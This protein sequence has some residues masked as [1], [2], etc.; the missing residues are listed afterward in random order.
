M[1]NP[2][3]DSCLTWAVFMSVVKAKMMQVRKVL[4]GAKAT[5]IKIDNDACVETKAMMRMTVQLGFPKAKHLA[6]S[7]LRP[8]Y[9]HGFP[10]HEIE[11]EFNANEIQAIEQTEAKLF[12]IEGK[13]TADDEIDL[14]PPEGMRQLSYSWIDYGTTVTIVTPSLKGLKDVEMLRGLEADGI[15]VHSGHKQLR[16]VLRPPTGA[17]VGCMFQLH[18]HIVPSESTFR[19][20]PGNRLA[21]TLCKAA[22]GTWPRLRSEYEIVD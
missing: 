7:H 2:S 6:V 19:L 21:I 13:D 12:W 4:P 15:E 1:A 20:R 9:S 17:V 16:V 11:G 8:A 3:C 14:V 10:T 22:P 5:E 18:G